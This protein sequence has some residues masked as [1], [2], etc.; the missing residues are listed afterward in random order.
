MAE[1]KLGPNTVILL[2]A[3]R[4]EFSGDDGKA[5]L[6]VQVHYV[7]LLGENSARQAGSVPLKAWFD[8]DDTWP[9][10]K[11]LA[12]QYPC[13]AD[14]VERRQMT[15]KGMKLVASD[16]DILP[17]DPRVR[18]AAVPSAPVLASVSR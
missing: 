17:G 4:M 2:G 11:A 15:N 9:K 10:Y 6:G 5:V 3:V 12:G 8:G 14:V 13:F 18:P 7:F 16:F 1:N